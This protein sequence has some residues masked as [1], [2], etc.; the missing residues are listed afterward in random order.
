KMS[1]SKGNM[2]FVREALRRTTPDGLRLY[3]LSKH[4]RR[5]FDH[6]DRS[7]RRHDDL[8]RELAAMALPRTRRSLPREAIDALERDLDTPAA[9]R[10]LSGYAKHGD[11][12][13]ATTLARHLGLRL[14]V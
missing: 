14:K 13:G 8:A 4:Y 3:L 7:L 5:P 9:I 11:A 2:V 12:E 6:D 1:K 10:L